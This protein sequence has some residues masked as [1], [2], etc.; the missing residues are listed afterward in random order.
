MK[1]PTSSALKG[2]LDGLLGSRGPQG[3]PTWH[4]NAKWDVAGGWISKLIE[5][6]EKASQ[7]LADLS[8]LKRGPTRV[9]FFGLSQSRLK[10][11]YG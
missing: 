9:P 10:P 7:A 3:H 1:H 4:S 8:P 11:R 5:Q 2:V 6:C